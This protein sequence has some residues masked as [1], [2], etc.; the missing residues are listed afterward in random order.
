MGLEMLTQAH[1]KPSEQINIFPHKLP[2]VLKVSLMV[3]TEQESRDTRVSGSQKKQLL[4]PVSTFPGAVSRWSGLL[5]CA[6]VYLSSFKPRLVQDSTEPEPNV[7]LES[8][9]VKTMEDI[10]NSVSLGNEA[11]FCPA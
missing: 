2:K 3:K 10:Q 1:N 4:M 5:S 11:V 9:A 7:T 6:S 8:G